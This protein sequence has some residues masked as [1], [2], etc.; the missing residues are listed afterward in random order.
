MDATTLRLILVVIGAVFLIGL[1]LW[2]R[3][4]AE[5]TSGARRVRRPPSRRKEEP[6]LG[7]F[8][9]G[10]SSAYGRSYAGDEDEDTLSYGASD[11]FDDAEELTPADDD[12]EDYGGE[13]PV[14]EAGA[15][16]VDE[17]LI[18]LYITSAGSAFSGEDILAAAERCKLRP[19]DMDI[20]H[21]TRGDV[22]DGEPL[23]SMANLVK[24]GIFPFDDMTEFASPGLAVFAQFRGEPSDLMVFDEM[25]DAAR[26][27]AELLGGDIRGPRREP[28]RDA[29]A[30]ALRA[31]VRAL[32]HG[33]AA[34]ADTP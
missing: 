11:A 3:Q 6:K 7:P 29:D 13:E 24:P 15:A 17:V 31:R 34:G 1:Y 10:E 8:D 30:K 27:M 26:I 21:R 12:Y 14:A 23:F 5:D 18:Q 9:D 28:L 32:L 16:A 2:E 22:P 19:G 20:F 25:L 33:N 4:R